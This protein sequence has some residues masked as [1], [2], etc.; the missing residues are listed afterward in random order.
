MI[1]W[2]DIDQ[3]LFFSTYG[4]KRE[5]SIRA[6]IYTHASIALVA[7]CNTE[8]SIDKTIL[9]GKWVS[10]NFDSRLTFSIVDFEMIGW[11]CEKP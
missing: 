1:A 5:S 6:I 8:T 2:N 4:T 7:K 3:N 10:S 11:L 9:V